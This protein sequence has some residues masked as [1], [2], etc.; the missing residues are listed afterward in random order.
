V[1]VVDRVAVGVVPDRDHVQERAVVGRVVRAVTVLEIRQVEVRCVEHDL[2]LIRLEDGVGPGHP[3]PDGRGRGVVGDAEVAVVTVAI[4]RDDATEVDPV[5]GKGGTAIVDR[6]DRCQRRVDGAV[7][8]VGP[9]LGVD[10]DPAVGSDREGD[11]DVDRVAILVVDANENLVAASARVVPPE[12]AV[13]LGDPMHDEPA[14][15]ASL[16]LTTDREPGGAAVIDDLILERP[17]SALDDD[18]DLPTNPR[19]RVL[20]VRPRRRLG[21]ARVHDVHVHLGG[22]GVVRRQS[23]LAG[24]R[25]GAVTPVG[26]IAGQRVRTA[27]GLCRVAGRRRV[28]SRVGARR[29]ICGRVGGLTR[30]AGIVAGARIGRARFAVVAGR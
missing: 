24:P 22:H 18:R 5:V 6:L 15:D 16:E 12:H 30:V 8:G 2:P 29:R 3:D 17:R 21:V 25:A 10:E 27:V 7:V 13:L 26:C 23:P 4:H 1:D 14:L 28:G 11:R 19:M 20:C 9:V